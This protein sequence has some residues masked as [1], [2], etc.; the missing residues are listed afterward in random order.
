MN[1]EAWWSIVHGVRK[2]Q[3]WLSDW[4]FHVCSS[5]CIYKVNNIEN[6][7]LTLKYYN[8][9]IALCLQIFNLSLSCFWKIFCQSHFYL[10]F[11]W[12][13]FHLSH[14]W[15][16]SFKAASCE[17]LNFSLDFYEALIISWV[18]FYYSTYTSILE[19]H[20]SLHIWCLWK[21]FIGIL[22]FHENCFLIYFEN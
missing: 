8:S 21:D 11:W 10:F 7:H 5:A 3:A 1:R 6:K 16:K 14:F 13:I 18:T 19:F 9:N 22:G 4:H 12:M 2:I 15:A 20:K 17:I